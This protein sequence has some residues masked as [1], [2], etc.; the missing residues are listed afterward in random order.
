M[1]WFYQQ[2]N[3]GLQKID[4]WIWQANTFTLQLPKKLYNNLK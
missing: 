4:V 1:F 2:L 3:A